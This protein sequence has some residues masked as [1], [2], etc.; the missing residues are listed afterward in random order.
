MKT[1]LRKWRD[2]GIIDGA[3][4]NPS[5]MLKDGVYDLERVRNV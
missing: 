4:T 2:Q 1:K 3:T 5:I